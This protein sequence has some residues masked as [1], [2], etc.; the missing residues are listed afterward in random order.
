MKKVV[1]IAWKNM[2]F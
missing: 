2:K 1:E